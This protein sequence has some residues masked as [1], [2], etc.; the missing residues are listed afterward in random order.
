MLESEKLCFF[1]A[2][3]WIRAYTYAWKT[4]QRNKCFQFE[5]W[6]AG[7]EEKFLF[8][9]LLEWVIEDLHI[10]DQLGLGILMRNPDNEHWDWALLERNLMEPPWN[11]AYEMFV[12]L[13][14][15]GRNGNCLGWTDTASKWSAWQSNACTDN[16]VFDPCDC[17][18][19]RVGH[20]AE[21]DVFEHYRSME[22]PHERD[23]VPDIL[24]IRDLVAAFLT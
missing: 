5:V 10:E 22:R 18:D 2:W 1:H 15:F 4:D 19:D 24:R 21:F 13:L 11:F 17:G 23:G 9:G 16:P 12:E 3:Y 6:K 14:S 7:I 8:V 20:A